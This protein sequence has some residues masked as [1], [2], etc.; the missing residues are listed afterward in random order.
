[1]NQLQNLLRFCGIIDTSV[2]RITERETP[3]AGTPPLP[4]DRGGGGHSHTR[5]EMHSES[6]SLWSATRGGEKR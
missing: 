5:G 6:V 4:P 3:T 1:M 2:V